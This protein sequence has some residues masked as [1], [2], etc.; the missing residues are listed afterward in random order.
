MCH[1]YHGHSWYYVKFQVNIMYRMM[2]HVMYQL[3]L[4]PEFL[5]SSILRSRV[6]ESKPKARDFPVFRSQSVSSGTFSLFRVTRSK[7]N[8]HTTQLLIWAKDKRKII[9]N[10]AENSSIS[11]PVNE[12]WLLCIIL[13]LE[14]T[15]RSLLGKLDYQHNVIND[16]VHCKY[17]HNDRI[18][19]YHAMIMILPT[20]KSKKH[21]P[22]RDF[23]D[24]RNS[25]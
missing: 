18:K 12:V 22:W 23:V 3:N 8:K 16:Y 4:V 7:C 14:P 20:T 25:W 21:M 1:T 11:R 2:Y 19:W 13:K 24:C 17:I 6:E 5:I 10:I 15:V 9:Q